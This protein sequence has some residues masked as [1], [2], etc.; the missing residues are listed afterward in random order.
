MTTANTTTDDGA[1]AGAPEEACRSI[2]ALERAAYELADAVE[3]EQTLEAQRPALKARIAARLVGTDNRQTDK[4][5]S[6]SSA[7]AAAGPDEEYLSH[8]RAVIAAT[9]AKILASGAFDA[10]KLRARLAVSSLERAG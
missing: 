5:H 10:A 8:C 7:D 1:R 4:P 2:D 6:A 3:R 9:R